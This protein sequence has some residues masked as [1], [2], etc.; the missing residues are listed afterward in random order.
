V[1]YSAGDYRDALLRSLPPGRA[2]TRRPDSVL[3]AL[4]EALAQE[5]V[6]VEGRR[7]DLLQE[8]DPSQASELLEDWERVAGLPELCGTPP[9]TEQERQDAL[10]AKL[11]AKPTPTPAAFVALG[12]KYGLT[13]SVSEFVPARCGIT[14]CNEPMRGEA[15]AHCFWLTVFGAGSG[16]EVN[17]ECEASSLKPAHAE[18]RFVYE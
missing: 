13:V 9:S 10:V 4:A 8:A 16:P 12:V 5:A 14:R 11:D 3:G 7:E 18:L 1:T 2:F 6:R 17:F 15:W